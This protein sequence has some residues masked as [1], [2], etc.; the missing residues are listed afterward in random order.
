[1]SASLTIKRHVPKACST[2]VCS[3]HHYRHKAPLEA[4][5]GKKKAYK[6]CFPCSEAL[7]HPLV[8]GGW[9]DYICYLWSWGFITSWPDHSNLCLCLQPTGV[10]LFR[11][12]W[13][14]TVLQWPGLSAL[15]PLLC[16]L[17]WYLL[18]PSF[19]L[20]LWLWFGFYLFLAITHANSLDMFLQ[21][22]LEKYFST[23]S[24]K[25]IHVF[26]SKVSHQHPVL[27]EK[28]KY[29]RDISSSFQRDLT[30]LANGFNLKWESFFPE[31][32][33]KNHR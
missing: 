33:K 27:M 21:H 32:C 29:L 3:R 4:S 30:F 18:P 9:G 2:C 28:L 17:C 26:T 16:H 8:S 23:Y 6:D 11:R 13:G 25:I 20:F 5:G 14:W 24:L 19:R 31:E 22:L 15:S 10:P 7:P 12:L 1:M